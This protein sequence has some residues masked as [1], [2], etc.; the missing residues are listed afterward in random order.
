MDV[1]FLSNQ[2]TKGRGGGGGGGGGEGELLSDL[3][4]SN[5]MEAS[6]LRVITILSIKC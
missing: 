6:D 3:C 5:N 4:H 1:A 2:L